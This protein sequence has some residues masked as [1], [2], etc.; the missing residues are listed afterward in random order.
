[1][2]DL[3]L[4]CKECGRY[5][6]L[7]GIHTFIGIVRCPSS[8]CKAQNQVKVVNSTSSEEDIRYKFPDIIKE[9]ETDDE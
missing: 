6:N 2:K 4:R 1:M 3:D 9:K 7:K 5:L 8:A